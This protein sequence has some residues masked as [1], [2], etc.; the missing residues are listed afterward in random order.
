M[1]TDNAN[2]MKKQRRSTSSERAE[3]LEEFQRSGLTRLAFSRSHSIAL[4]TLSKWLYNAKHKTKDAVPVLFRELK[5]RQVPMI[6]TM[7][8]AVEIVGPDGLVVRCRE[9]L[10]LRDVSWLL[11]GR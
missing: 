11:R 8:W 4:S 1:E 7:A 2:G 10:P 5:V 3:I 9:A 6:A